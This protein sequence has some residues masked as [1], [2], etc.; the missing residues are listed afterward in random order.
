MTDSLSFTIVATLDERNIRFI[1]RFKIVSAW[2]V[3]KVL[4]VVAC[5]MFGA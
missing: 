1:S 4:D 2:K 5:G 3:E